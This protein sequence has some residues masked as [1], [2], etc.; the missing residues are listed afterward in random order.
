VF[1]HNEKYRGVI[2]WNTSE[3]TKNPD[4]GMRRRKARPCSELITTRNEELRI[5]S[6][7]LFERAQA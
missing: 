7:A 6:D 3:W 5:V 2:H 1:V 4:S